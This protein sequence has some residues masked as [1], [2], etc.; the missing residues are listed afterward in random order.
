[1]LWVDKSSCLSCQFIHYRD[2]IMGTMAYQITTLTTVYSTVYS[3]SDQRKHQSFGS[4]AFVPVN[5]PHKW[6]VTWKMSP[7]DDVIMYALG[8][9]GCTGKF[10]SLSWEFWVSLLNLFIQWAGNIFHN[11]S[12]GGIHWPYYKPYRIWEEMLHSYSGLHITW[13]RKLTIC[14]GNFFSDT[15]QNMLMVIFSYSS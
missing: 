3:D 1:M 8:S 7:F 13:A 6:P 15:V 12:P 5:S 11:K 10:C 2:I 14:V 9:R 4:L